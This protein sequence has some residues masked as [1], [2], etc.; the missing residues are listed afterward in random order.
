MSESIKHECGIALLRLLKPLSY[1]QEKYGTA[2][3]GLTKLYLLMEKQRNRGQ[4]GAGVVNL[5][6]DVDPGTKY[7][8]RYR[9]TSHNALDEI[10]SKINSRFVDLE[11]NA[12]EKLSNTD[13][14]KK[15]VAFTGE[16]FLGHLRYGTYGKNSIEYYIPFSARI[17]G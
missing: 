11:K 9:S 14:L 1:Y 10:F 17:T 4:D 2:L 8:S 15:N 3:Y 7:I 12:P 6:L 13:W 5:K 16:L